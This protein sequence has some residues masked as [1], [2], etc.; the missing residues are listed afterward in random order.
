MKIKDP[1]KLVIPKGSL[2]QA[3]IE[4]FRR[5][6]WNINVSPRNYFPTID[7]D[8]IV[9]ARLRAQE[10]SQYVQSGIFDVGL[11]GK[12]WI[13]EN[14]SDVHVI[15]DLVYSKVSQSPARW[16]LAVDGESSYHVPEDLKGKRIA[17]ELV[18][19]TRKFFAERGIPVEVEFS[20]GSTEAKVREGVVDAIV[21]VTETGSTLRANGLRIIH[22]LLTTNTQLIANHGA[23]KDPFK[24]DKVQQ[25]H[26][27]LQAALEA[28]KMVGLKMNVPK[29]RVDTI[30]G[31]LPSLN[32]PTVSG[33][34]KSDWFAVEVVVSEEVVRSLIPKLLKSGAAGIIEYSLNKVL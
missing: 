27:L 25:I 34:Y 5:A 26:L 11:T 28:R 21:D 2:E 16:V 32:A 12:D 15:D 24:K 1:I 18:R 13:L 19:F 8:E 4:L 33:L 6:G 23:Y 31:L 17:T 29:D 22:N 9:V 20:W 3:T 14:E 10:I 7:D 30:V